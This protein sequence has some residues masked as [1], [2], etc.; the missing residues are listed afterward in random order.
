M[1]HSKQTNLPRRAPVE[2]S[3]SLVNSKRAPT[4]VANVSLHYRHHHLKEPSRAQRLA[5]AIKVCVKI[6]DLITSA[7]TTALCWLYVYKSINVTVCRRQQW[8]GWLL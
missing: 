3:A 7:G 2:L 6:T 4:S 5:A 1:D 8:D